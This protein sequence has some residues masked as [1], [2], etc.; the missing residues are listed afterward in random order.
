[1]V[2]TEPVNRPKDSRDYDQCEHPT[3]TRVRVQSITQ[4][5]QEKRLNVSQRDIFKFCGV[6]H[7]QGYQLLKNDISDRRV[8]NRPENQWDIKEN[9]PGQPRE[10]KR[11][12]ADTDLD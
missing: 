5:V 7:T 4:F 8:V 3:P 9:K 10:R 6:G 1:M 11:K 2:T 12:L